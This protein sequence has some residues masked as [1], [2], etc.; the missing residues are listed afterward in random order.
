MLGKGKHGEFELTEGCPECIT[1]REGVDAQTTIAVE[2]TPATIDEPKTAVALRPGEDITVRGY[3]EESQSILAY[4]ERRVIATLEDNKLASDDLTIISRIKR[5]M[6]AKKREYLEPLGAQMDTIR[7]TY[8]FLMAPILEAEKATKSKMLAYSAEQSRIRNE[9]EEINRKRMEA[10]QQEIKL[11]GALSEPVDLVEVQSVS[12]RVVTDMG[13]SGQRDNWKF[14]IVDVDAL[15][16]EY[17]VPDDVMLKSIAKNH[18]D[19]KA[20]K[21]VRFYNEP[22]LRVSR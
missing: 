1:E 21:G 7:G 2:S 11:K 18:H 4:A 5:A 10:A 22:G 15:P 19:Q 16:R 6:E 20:V 3:F 8:N 12:K 14:E 13:S 17:M 9:Q